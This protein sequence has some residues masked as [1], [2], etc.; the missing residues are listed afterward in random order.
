M[1]ENMST[2]TIGTTTAANSLLVVTS[3]IVDSMT[4][5][6][7]APT[8]STTSISVFLNDTEDGEGCAITTDIVDW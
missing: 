5:A 6:P 2:T 7:S 1:N 3:Y 8:Y 4:D